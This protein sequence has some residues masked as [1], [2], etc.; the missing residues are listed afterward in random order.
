MDN[1]Q[2]KKKLEEILGVA[3]KKGATDIHL[4]QGRPFI[5]RIDGN[6]SFS[7]NGQILTAEDTEGL[8]YAILAE[9]RKEQF[10]SQRDIDLSFTYKD[11]T[12][13][14]V[15]IYYQLGKIS[16]ALRLIPNK[17]MTIE[18]LNLPLICHQLSEAPQGFFLAVGPSGQGKS[19]AL[20]AIVNEINHTRQDHIV[21]IEDPVEHIFTQD[22]CIVD[23][24]EVG[25][26]V[27]NFHRGLREVL[28]QDPDVIMI[29][30]MRD[31]ETISSAVTAAETGHLVLTTLHTNNA[32][33]TVDRIIDSFPPHQQNQIRTQLAAN[34]LG[35]LSRRLIPCLKGS[36]INAVE[37][38]IANSAIRNLIREG[39]THQINMVIET[40]SEE[41]M[42]SLNRSLADLVKRELI[43]LEDAEK[44]SIRPSE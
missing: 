18:E 28:R 23:Q 14:R 7:D 30:E 17:I 37:L 13:F 24:R 34:I 6:L 32:A 38:M 11:K 41:G 25:E 43:S 33:Q 35:I 21:T 8:A 44:H 36:V 20:A 27:Q 29:G 42:I 15:N 16:V 10:V 3:I 39:K 40:S 5:L 9:E 26:D 2:Y 4:S 22:K 12:R 19:A 31:T 1:G